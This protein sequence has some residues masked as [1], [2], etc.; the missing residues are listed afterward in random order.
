MYTSN[1]ERFIMKETQ[2]QKSNVKV[3]RIET[4]G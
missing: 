3:W 2:R 1:A 4:I